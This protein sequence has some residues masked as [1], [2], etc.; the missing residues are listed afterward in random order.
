MRELKHEDRERRRASRHERRASEDERRSSRDERR[1]SH[2]HGRRRS[3][4]LLVTDPGS[5]EEKTISEDTLR[6]AFSTPN[7]TLGKVPD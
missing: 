3:Q 7:L 1:S 6:V 2:D 5:D 4:S